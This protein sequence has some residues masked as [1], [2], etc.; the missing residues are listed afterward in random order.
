MVEVDA[1]ALLP[2]L[3]RE[4]AFQ[5]RAPALFETAAVA[6]TAGAGVRYVFP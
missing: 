1:C 6:A 4:A 2:L 3:H 5:E